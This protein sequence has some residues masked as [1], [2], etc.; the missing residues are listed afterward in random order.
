MCAE[1]HNQCKAQTLCRRF[2]LVTLLTN[3]QL[4]EWQK[5]WTISRKTKL[6]T[7]LHNDTIH[8]TQ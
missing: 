3:D 4:T 1:D 5:K 2:Q 7:N 8:Y 6:T